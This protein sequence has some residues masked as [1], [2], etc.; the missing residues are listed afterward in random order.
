MTS[1]KKPW[2]D[3]TYP[4]SMTTTQRQEMLKYVNREAAGVMWR[5]KIERAYKAGWSAK[6]AAVLSLE[7]DQK[8]SKDT[9]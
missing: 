9:K 3:V 5:D 1:E 7:E 4:V 8:E 6:T 2:L